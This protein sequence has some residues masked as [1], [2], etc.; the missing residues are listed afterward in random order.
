MIALSYFYK[1]L[2]EYDI[3]TGKSVEICFN[4]EETATG[5]VIKC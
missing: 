1:C 4:D 2:K 3:V 5:Q